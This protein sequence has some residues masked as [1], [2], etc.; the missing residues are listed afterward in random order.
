MKKSIWKKLKSAVGETIGETLVALL[1]SSLALMMLAGAVSAATR[2]ITRSQTTMD[3]YY[4]ANNALDARTGAPGGSLSI[5][6]TDGATS[7]SLAPG[8]A[9]TVSYYRND[10]LGNIPVIAYAAPESGGVAP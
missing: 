1:I 8:Q 3:A 5:A 9:S 7:V 10:Q 2:M 4:R 6:L